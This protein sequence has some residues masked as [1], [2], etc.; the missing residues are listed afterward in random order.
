MTDAREI[1]RQPKIKSAS[2]AYSIS[3]S[4]P[5]SEDALLAID[6]YPEIPSP[7]VFAADPLHALLTKKKL[8]IVEFRSFLSN[9][10]RSGTLKEMLHRSVQ[11]WLPIQ[12]AAFQN[13]KIFEVLMRTVNDCTIKKDG[14]NLLQ[15]IALSS[16]MNNF[17]VL[18]EGEDDEDEDDR[19]VLQKI[20]AFLANKNIPLEGP[21]ELPPTHI[22]AYNGHKN[23]LEAI[24]SHYIA[25]KI[26]ETRRP[27]NILNKVDTASLAPIH[28]AV[29][30]D[31]AEVIDYLIAMDAD[32][33]KVGPHL[34]TAL[35]FACD[36]HLLIAT[37][38]LLT[39]SKIE[40]NQKDS[41]NC[42]PLDLVQKKSSEISIESQQE[43]KTQVEYLI[44]H[45][46]KSATW[47]T[48]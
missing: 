33:N 26:R 32:V 16:E 41:L 20:I 2:K 43:R 28:Y 17:S 38:R 5:I 40:L 39:V 37:E 25:L 34:R 9:A 36:L 15:L 44:R 12:L 1:R 6:K 7:D 11:G 8:D 3:S 4:T 30:S 24:Y 35:H 23:T 46:L 42:T 21:V 10:D 18:E 45:G 22:A 13:P 27:I 14:W 19:T 47:K 48:S 31:N 29:M